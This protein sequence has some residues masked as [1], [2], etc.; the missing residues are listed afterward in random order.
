MRVRQTSFLCALLTCGCYES[1]GPSGDARED[2]PIEALVDTIGEVDAHESPI[3]TWPEGTETCVPPDDVFMHWTVDGE[4]GEGSRNLEIPCMVM[5]VVAEDVD[6]TIVEL[7]CG[8][9]G[10]FE[11]HFV[12]IHAIP[13]PRLGDLAGEDVTLYSVSL[14][15]LWQER[16]FTLRHRRGELIMAGLLASG[17]SPAFIAVEEW[18]DPLGVRLV[19]DLCV[20]EDGECGPNERA[21]LDIEYG[22]DSTLVFDGTSGIIGGGPAMHVIVDVARGWNPVT[23]WDHPVTRIGALFVLI[24]EG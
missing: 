13:H 4:E 8:Y 3:D 14:S 6:S 5:D 16:W 19:T 23:C 7:E 2:F 24:P 17:L 1:L 22:G 12:E 9:E 15:G 21:A 11:W 18:Y 20:Q 10:A